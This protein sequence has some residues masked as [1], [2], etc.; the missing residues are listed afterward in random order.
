MN[1]GDSATRQEVCDEVPPTRTG[2]ENITWPDQVAPRSQKASSTRK[3]KP[4]S[5]NL[6]FSPIAP[7]C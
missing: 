7:G 5:S 2:R 4:Q 6:I 3:F 1:L